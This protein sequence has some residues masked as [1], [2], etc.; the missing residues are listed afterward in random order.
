M[1][2][3]L[4]PQQLQRFGAR[5]RRAV[6]TKAAIRRAIK[7]AEAAGLRVARVTINQDGEV[8][9]DSSEPAAIH[10]DKQSRLAGWED[11]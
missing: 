3:N 7:A 10:N 6:L 11:I 9:I 4:T 8:I 1:T 5:S 2:S